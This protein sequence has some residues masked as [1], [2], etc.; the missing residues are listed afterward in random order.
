MAEYLTEL[1]STCSAL[2]TNDGTGVYHKDEDC[3]ECVKDLI[4]FLRRDDGNN[5]TLRRAIGSIGVVKC[6]L[7]P[8]LRDHSS[9]ADLFDM[10]LR[11]VVNLTSPELLLFRQELPE[12]KDTRN[13]FLQLQRHRQG[14]L[15]GGFL[16]WV[17]ILGNY[18]L[19]PDI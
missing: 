19:Y 5:H 6:D 14:E 8:I 3:L 4:R 16:L 7:I 9:D 2:G 17:V 12:D 10:V 13:Y 15:L 1:E 11:L 18:Q